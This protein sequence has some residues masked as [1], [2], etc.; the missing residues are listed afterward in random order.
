[1][2]EKWNAR[3]YIAMLWYVSGGPGQTQLSLKA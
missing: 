3:V 2:T 1:M